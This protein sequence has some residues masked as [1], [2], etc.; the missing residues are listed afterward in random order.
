MSPLRKKQMTNHRCQ[1]LHSTET[2]TVEGNTI[3]IQ[4]F[5]LDMEQNICNF[6]IPPVINIKMILRYMGKRQVCFST[7]C[8]DI[9]IYNQSNHILIFVFVNLPRSQAVILTIQPQQVALN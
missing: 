5:C 8:E 7:R 4:D 9:E 6:E 2:T 3:E 1:H